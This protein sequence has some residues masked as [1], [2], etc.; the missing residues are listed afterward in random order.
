MKRA[1]W[2]SV[3]VALIAGCSKETPYEKPLTPVR[4]MPVE[5]SKGSQAPRYSGNVEPLTRVDLAFRVGGYVDQILTVAGEG[6]PRLVQE[7]DTVSKGAVLVRLRQSDYEVKVNQAKSQV[8]QAKAAI[9]QS[10]EGLKGARVGRDKAQLDYDR[11]GN[12]FRSQ[13]LAKPDFDGAKAQLDGAQAQLDG[14]EAQLRLAQARLKGAQ[15]QLEEAEIAQQDTNLK[16]SI[17]AVVM[18]RLVELG[19]L[20][21][22]GSP[23]FVLGDLSRVKMVFGV[24]DT[25]LPRL[26]L[27]MPLTVTTEAVP[28]AVFASQI[29]RI[30]PSADARS[31]AFEV[32]VTLPNPGQRLKAGMI[33]SIQIP[34]GKPMEPMPVVPLTAVVQPKT[35]GAA[36]RVFVVEE[37]AGKPVSKARDVQLGP[38]VGDRIA[39]L[40]GLRAGERVVITGAS[41]VHDGE[42]VEIVP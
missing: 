37:Q 21:G 38:A 6:R 5:M 26:K 30:A 27:G 28:G 25:L 32:E 24:P 19:T 40:Q 7:G 14:A 33:A 20:V 1:G 41:M 29:T 23:A 8:D 9:E 2:L 42:A 15:A 18:K 12:L 3:A 11:A 13:S 31:R 17:D 39:V 35:G 4:V 16:A 22:P 36:Y 34:E 10:Q